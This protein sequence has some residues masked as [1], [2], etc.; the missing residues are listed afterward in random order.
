MRDRQVI[1]LSIRIDNIVEMKRNVLGGRFRREGTYIL[2]W[3]IH[4]DIWQ[5][6]T[7]YC[8]AIIL[9]LKMNTFLK[10]NVSRGKTGIR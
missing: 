3:L 8:I 10:R 5:K 7:Q 1:Y 2:L 6:P 9:Q 4:G